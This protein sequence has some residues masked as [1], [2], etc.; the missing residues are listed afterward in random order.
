MEKA[1]FNWSSGKDS[2][3]ALYHALRS[4]EFAVERLF[5]VLK[6]GGGR[7]AMHEVSAQLLQRQAD[8][9]GIAWTPFYFDAEWSEETYASAMAEQMA[10]F[11]AQGITTALFGDLYLEELRGSR[12]RNCAACGMK[13]AFPLWH[14]PPEEVMDE[15]LRLGFRAVITCVDGAVLPGE[16]VGRIIDREL[17]A[18]FPS[19]ADLCGE[20]GEYHSFV[21]DG[22]LFK[23]PVDFGRGRRCFR[24]YP[25]PEGV[26]R[27]WYLELG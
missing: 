4:G 1:Y 12:E 18:Q 2:A 21:F 17:L 5:S 14:I 19:N 13:A 26:H 16:F 22:P 20:N 7:L 15:F 23:A 10:R 8:A 9:I 6:A 3:L 11:Q 25:C 24:D 27:Y